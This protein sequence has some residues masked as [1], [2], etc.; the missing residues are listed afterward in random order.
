VVERRRIPVGEDHSIPWIL[1]LAQTIDKQ[2]SN[3]SLETKE[4]SI[5]SSW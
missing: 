3:T 2:Q 4:L 5:A 1:S